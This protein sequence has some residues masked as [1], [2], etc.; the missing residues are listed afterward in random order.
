MSFP[1]RVILALI[2][3]TAVAGVCVWAVI[4]GPQAKRLTVSQR[5]IRVGGIVIVM[6][7]IA[8]WVIFFWPAYWESSTGK[9][10]GRLRRAASF[11]C[12]STRAGDGV[13]TVFCCGPLRV[14]A[15]RR[16]PKNLLLLE[17]MGFSLSDQDVR[18]VNRL[19][20]LL[21]QTLDSLPYV[22]RSRPY[23]R[24]QRRAA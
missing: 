1:L 8:A 5:M 22:L 2:L 17:E 18:P 4:A 11:T 23:F 7:L 12:P 21:Y 19:L 16:S 24:R 10:H 15:V 3:I 6:A 9:S 13:P 14:M 20:T